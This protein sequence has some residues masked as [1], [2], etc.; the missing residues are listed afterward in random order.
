MAKPSKVTAAEKKT[1]DKEKENQGEKRSMDEND[2]NNK[3]NSKT[4]QLE[5]R[6]VKLHQ[7]TLG[8]REIQHKLK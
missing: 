6:H 8:D 5:T 7:E 3:N 4:N 1:K 2:K